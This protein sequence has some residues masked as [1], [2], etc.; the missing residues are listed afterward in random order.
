M[1]LPIPITFIY[2]L[3]ENMKFRSKIFLVLL[4]LIFTACMTG[5]PEGETQDEPEELYH[6]GKWG[7]QVLTS[8]RLVMREEDD[9]WN[10]AWR[11]EAN[12]LLDEYQDGSVTGV[13]HVQLFHW[14]M[15]SGLIL[16]YEDIAI[17]RWDQYAILDINLHGTLTDEG[18]ELAVEQLPVSLPDPNNLTAIIDFWDFLYP[19]LLEG[20]WPID[21]A[22]MM[23]GDSVRVQGS[24]YGD[25]CHLESFREFSIQYTWEIEKL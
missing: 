19:S 11:I 10:R 4:I 2:N 18:Y 16:D 24:D 23:S 21:D 8:A 7:G 3:C 6:A 9:Y 12:I 15:H 1:T 14:D 22:C 13:A 5:C 25:T 20:N 17:G